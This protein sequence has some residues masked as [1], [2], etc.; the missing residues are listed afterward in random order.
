VKYRNASEIFPDELLKEIQ[1]YSSGELVY[2]PESKERKD[3]GSKSGAR[4]Y[5]LK[6]NS[7]IRDKHQQERKKISQLA[8]EYG[9]STDTIRRILYK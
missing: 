2:I 9:L 5:Y 7:E 4:A 1:K 8:E 3:W 6:R